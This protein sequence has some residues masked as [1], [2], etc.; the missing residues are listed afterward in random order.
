[1]PSDWFTP[2]RPLKPTEERPFVP[3]PVPEPDPDPGFEFH[4]HALE[5]GRRVATATPDAAG[6]TTEIDADAV[7]EVI[8]HEL[9]DDFAPA[10]GAEVGT[11]AGTEVGT[12][13]EVGAAAET[14][15]EA[16]A[17]TAKA[18]AETEFAASTA[19]TLTS[20]PASSASPDSTMRLRILR[21]KPKP[22]EPGYRLRTVPESAWSAAASSRRVW[23]SR[24]VL[25]CVLVIQAALSL[26]LQNTAFEDEALYLYAGHVEIGH[27]LHGTPV[28]GG[29][30]SYFSGAPVLYPVLA[31]VVDTYFGLTGARTL[32]LLFM[33]GCTALLYA[34]TRRLF[35]ERAGL[36]AA[37]IFAIAQSTA[38]M[39]EFATYDACALF[40]LALAAWL[41]V[42]TAGSRPVWILLAAP[43]AALAVAV[44]YASALYLPT[45]VLL[46]V[47]V[48]YQRR[49]LL[50]GLLRGVLLSVATITVLGVGLYMSGYLQ[51]IE[52]TT[53]SRAQGVV[54]ASQI[55]HDSARWV[56]PQL[57][58]AAFGAF[59]YVRRSRMSEM[60]GWR[61]SL[62]GARWR[63]ALGLLLV[64][65]GL[66]APAYQLHLHTEVSLHKHVGY[67]LL[68]AAPLAGVGVTRLM[69]PHFKYPQWAILITVVLLSTG[70]SQA[71][72]NYHTWPDSTQLISTLR[73]YVQPN[74][75][76]LADTFEVPVYY[77]RDEVGYRQWNSTYTIDYTTRDGRHLTGAAGFQAAIAEGHFDLVVLDHGNPTGESATIR[78]ALLS[79]GTYRLI[80]TVP[81]ATVGGTSHFEIWARN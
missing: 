24:A 2:A 72:D 5:T 22:I 41:A 39:G 56:G 52:A 21:L 73:P 71:Y 7:S 17:G 44:K 60:P 54:S 69:G 65:T 3:L 33:L 11:E 37:G 40:L 81:Y 51:A 79:D 76:Y 23:V 70:M 77:L 75:H 1:M 57:A 67:G 20:S 50:G 68:F 29:F 36:C 25:V 15:A 63:T 13:T 62:P 64:G 42:R 74:G 30:D 34:M 19:S 32:S 35:N 58:I 4:P 46:A 26:R 14:A 66:L 31:A 53:T 6:E 10:A 48:A 12:E 9:Y 55:L 27:L 43:V 61:G 59:S 49:G 8:T 45:I 47:L 38:F 80:G 16:E 78:S 18:T 28:Y